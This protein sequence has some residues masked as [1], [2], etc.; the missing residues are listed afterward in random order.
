MA[1]A[2][3]ANAALDDIVSTHV[4]QPTSDFRPEGRSSSERGSMKSAADNP[5]RFSSQLPMLEPYESRT[6]F[7]AHQHEA[8][9]QLIAQ[10]QDGAKITTVLDEVQRRRIGQPQPRKSVGGGSTHA[11]P[12]G[13]ALSAASSGY[14]GYQ[15]EEDESRIHLQM[16]SEHH[17]TRHDVLVLLES[18]GFVVLIGALIGMIA[19]G[20]TFFEGLL[21]QARNT[22]VKSCFSDLSVGA[23]YVAFT[24]VNSGYILVA[25]LLTSWAPMAARSG[26][27]PLKAFLNGVE[28]PGL[29]SA[30]TLV[31]KI[32]GVTCVVATGIPLGREGP[33][34]HTGAIVASRVTRAEYHGR[35]RTPLEM[36]VPSAQRNWVGIGAAAG[37]AAAFNSPLGGILYS[38]EEVCSHWSETM[39]WRAFIVRRAHCPRVATRSGY[40]EP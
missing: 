19:A 24:G 11:P 3:P 30:R 18:F 12:K 22:L 15:F 25:S 23:A 31:A 14:E 4:L 1:T 6:S 37:V 35:R 2:A 27:P 32:L 10:L 34:V 5:P 28:V 36:R 40:E 33:M 16:R 39:T 13:A 20:I 17:A 26:L 8:A 9:E 29:L 21:I 7:D 38:F